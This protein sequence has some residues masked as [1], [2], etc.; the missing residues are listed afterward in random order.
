[1]P[2]PFQA[3]TRCC[4]TTGRKMVPDLPERFD[5][6]YLYFYSAWQTQELNQR[7]ANLITSLAHITPGMEVLD[8]PCGF[9]RIAN[10]LAG[11]G[12]RVT[13]LDASPLFLQ[14][15]RRDASD[16]GI[17]LD[18][19][20]GDMRQLPWKERFDRIV[21]WFVSFG[22]FD[23][24]TDRRVLAGFRQALRHGGQLI[25]SHTNLPALLRNLPSVGTP[26]IGR[27]L[28]DLG[29]E[30]MF[31]RSGYN[32]M[33]GRIEYHRVVV[34]G[35]RVNRQSFSVR[36]FTFTEL[37]E[38]LE[39]AGFTRIEAYGGDGSLLTLNTPEMIVVAHR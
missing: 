13:G 14:R 11:L 4:V 10:A 38:W 7:E 29:D 9:G 2:L 19:V 37:R 17:T 6:D 39:H 35:G 15:A 21:C 12:C 24:A 36:G 27:F 33:S 5:E 25:V 31:F 28:A 18:Y 26:A 8:V 1:L 22:Y 3:N 23:D 30:F 16:L 34:R 20:E 32:V